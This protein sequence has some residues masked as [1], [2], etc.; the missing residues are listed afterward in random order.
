[1]YLCNIHGVCDLFLQTKP[2]QEISCGCMP[3]G[4]G[5]STGA[6]LWRAEYH[7]WTTRDQP[8]VRNTRARSG[9]LLHLQ[10]HEGSRSSNCTCPRT[11]S[12]GCAFI[13]MQI[14]CI[15]CACMCRRLGDAKWLSKAML[16]L[17]YTRIYIYITFHL[18]IYIN[19]IR[20][21]LWV[22]I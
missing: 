3:W 20:E 6:S 8:G 17:K 15:A 21:I 4:E 22:L 11:G 14:S 2:N 12:I 1:M 16:C 18:Y 5:M 13:S 7:A 10:G 9:T 19:F